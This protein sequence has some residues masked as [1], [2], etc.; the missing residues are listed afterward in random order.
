MTL[1]DRYDVIREI[2][3]GAM[4]EVFLAED[5][6]LNR[7]VALKILTLPQGLDKTEK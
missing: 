5:K 2:G 4:G 6:V 3:R 7:K 1:S